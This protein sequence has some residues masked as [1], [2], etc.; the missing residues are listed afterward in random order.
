MN[1]SCVDKARDISCGL[2]VMTG[3]NMTKQLVQEKFKQA[4]HLTNAE[5]VFVKLSTE[6]QFRY[7]AC[8]SP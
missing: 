8:S 7:V 2:A 6:K 1:T 3:Q 5:K 4:T